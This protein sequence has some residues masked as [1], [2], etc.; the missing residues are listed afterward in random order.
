MTVCWCSSA[1]SSPSFVHCA[2]RAPFHPHRDSFRTLGWLSGCAPNLAGPTG[3]TYA[4]IPSQLIQENLLA[5][6]RTGVCCNSVPSECSSFQKRPALRSWATHYTHTV[7]HLS[8]KV[9]HNPQQRSK[10]NPDVFLACLYMPQ[11]ASHLVPPFSITTPSNYETTCSNMSPAA[12]APP[13]WL[14]ITINYLHHP[15][16]LEKSS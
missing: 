10:T 7:K 1:S 5:Q 3:C 4:V 14:V 15:P 2:Q 13:K 9:H 6:I 11:V 12:G 8:L 16:V